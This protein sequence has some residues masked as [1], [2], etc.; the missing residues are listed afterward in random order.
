MPDPL[1]AVEVHQQAGLL[2]ALSKMRRSVTI[3]TT[4]YHGVRTEV[5][6]R[7]DELKLGGKKV[8]RMFT[9]CL[10]R[11]EL[12]ADVLDGASV[13]DDLG[14]R[15]VVISR[16]GDATQQTLTCAGTWG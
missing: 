10:P 14:K 8:K 2:F 9:I 4:V 13:T 16:V 11:T 5:E 6:V 7:T 1:N 12:A 15:Y 3:N